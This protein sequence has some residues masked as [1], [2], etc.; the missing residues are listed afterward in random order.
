MSLIFVGDGDG[1]CCKRDFSMPLVNFFSGRYNQEDTMLNLVEPKKSIFRSLYLNG[2][3][4]TKLMI[5]SGL[6]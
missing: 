2:K 4:L 6:F 1:E 3:S 5:F